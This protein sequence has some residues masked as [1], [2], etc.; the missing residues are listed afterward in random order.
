MSNPI[1]GLRP[2]KYLVDNA[3][4]DCLNGPAQEEQSTSECEG[5]AE[6]DVL[7]PTRGRRISDGIL[8]IMSRLNLGSRPVGDATERLLCP[9]ELDAYCNNHTETALHIAVR[10][11]HGDIVNGLLAAGT[12]P[13]LL[14]QRASG[15]QPQLGQSEE[16]MSALEEACLN[17]DI[18]VVDLL[19]KHGA[20]DDDCR[21]LAVV[22]KNKDD[23]LTAKLLS[24][25]A[26]PDPEN[27]INKKAMSEQVPAA[28]TQFSGLQSLTY[29]NMFANTPVMINWHC[30]R[31]QLSQI[32]PQWLVDAALHVNPKLRLNPRSQDLV[33]YAITRL[34]VS[35]NSL[36][37][38]PSVVFQ[39]QSLRH[40]N[41][42]HNKIEKL[43]SEKDSPQLDAGDRG[44][45]KRLKHALK[46]YSAP[47][48]EELYLQYNRLEVLPDEVFSL[49][50]L[51][52]LDVS[53]NKLP[54]L[55]C[56]MW[57]APKL[58]EL[59][60]A[61]NLLK[62]LPTLQQEDM[63]DT[64]SV[65][66]MESS[67]SVDSQLSAVSDLP[68][69]L[70]PQ[71]PDHEPSPKDRNV[72]LLDLTQHNLWSRSVQ[73]MEQISSNDEDNSHDC[74]HLSALNLA[75]NQFTAIPNTLSC[76]AVNLT[77][78]NMAYNSLRS[79]GH[80]TSYPSSLKQLD[81]SH[82]RVCCWPSLPQIEVMDPMEQAA[83]ACYA[84][85]AVCK[86]C[87]PVSGRRQAGRSLRTAILNSLCAHRR[88]LR[89]DNLRTLV[90]ADNQLLRIQL[91]TDDDGQ[92]LQ[93]N[94]DHDPEWCRVP[95]APHHCQSVVLLAKC[96]FL[97]TSENHLEQNLDC[98]GMRTNFP[99]EQV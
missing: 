72:Q 30:Q 71:T 4:L 50:G 74:S 24:I 86:P 95:G 75:H 12:N 58:K 15:E 97:G 52:T 61:F 84:V 28:S 49:P 80:I 57:R 3:P 13:N 19:L 21:A 10:G 20:R 88:H 25:K 17:R 6:G 62:D 27:R 91:T 2:T 65:C 9:W 67:R 96:S 92:I 8:G 54:T 37:W 69:I 42:A 18:A 89:L 5:E 76:L 39:L 66:S 29:S 83:I 46:Q 11:R 94:E 70:I 14:T 23:I 77:R 34:D 41:L 45:K 43:P 78:L 73:V 7:S 26:H 68:P 81:L 55:P 87:R 60:A 56:K 59:N 16:A 98:R 99:V 35:N 53:N 90:L 93:E 40:L 1:I 79:M 48:L 47:L 32:R 33:L 63:S 36:T 31:C 44:N 51:V 82:N 22:V 38:V 64:A 85:D